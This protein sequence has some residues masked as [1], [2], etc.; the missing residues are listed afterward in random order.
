MLLPRSPP[1]QERA[2]QHDWCYNDITMSRAFV[3]DSEGEE[4]LPEIPVS[5]H[6]NHVTPSGL[7]ALRNRLAAAH[8]ARDRLRQD[9]EATETAELGYI[10]RELRW[11][12][13]RVATAM[14]V[15]LEHQPSDRVAFGATVDVA[16]SDGTEATWRIVGEDEADVEHGWVS[17]VSPLAQALLGARVGEEV[18][19]HRP[20]GDMRVEV[21]AIRYE[22]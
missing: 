12:E 18:V 6:A 2:A 16:A 20:I 8:A 14:L 5:E 22:G 19:W 21:L 11:L 7:A 10:E 15:D 9:A 3:K 13:A 17:W 1:A 4:E